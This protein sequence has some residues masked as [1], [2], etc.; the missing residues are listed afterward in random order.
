M[1]YTYASFQQAL[2]SEMV[3]PNNNVLDPNFVLILPT[4][5]DYAEQRCYRELDCLH[6]ETQQWFPMVPFQRAQTFLVEDVVQANPTPAQQILIVERVMIE[7]AGGTCV[8]SIDDTPPANPV[9][10]QLWWDS[11]GGQLYIWYDDGTTAQWVVTNNPLRSAAAG[12]AAVAGNAPGQL[13][14]DNEGG[15]LYIWYNDGNSSQWVSA[16]NLRLN[17]TTRLRASRGRAAAPTR[18]TTAGSPVLP[19]TVDYLDMVYSGV[20]PNPGPSGLPRYFAPLTDT[21]LAF[22]PVPDKAYRFRIQGKCRPIPLY[23]AAPKDGTQT[24]FLTQ[25]L[26][27]LFLA[28]AMVSASGY[29]HNF[30]AQSDDPRMAVSWEGQYNELLGSAKNEETRKRFLG[31]NQ[32]S[33]YS[34]TQAAQPAPAPAG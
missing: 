31:W 16:T 8:V 11:I 4:I 7:P 6:A 19:T 28:A 15:Q 24:T 1:S 18:P 13:G 12:A 25:V 3:V 32:L 9:D 21:M 10:G 17:A 20:F 34:A 33:S 14:W 23:N 22:G 30:G 29:R 5:I 2:A 27:D 26:P